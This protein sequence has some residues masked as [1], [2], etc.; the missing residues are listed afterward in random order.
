MNKKAQRLAIAKACGWE[1]KPFRDVMAWYKDGQV[2]RSHVGPP[3]VKEI[4]VNSLPD[5]LNDLNAMYQAEETLDEDLLFEYTINIREAT[6][7]G[8][9]FDCIHASAIERAEAFLKTIEKWEK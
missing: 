6:R 3:L 1:W 4:P 5:Y 7:V 9:R 2:V 8:S